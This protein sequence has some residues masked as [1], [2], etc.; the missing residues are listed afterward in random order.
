MTTLPLPLPTLPGFA[1]GIVEV[2]GDLITV[3]CDR[4][5]ETRTDRPVY[6]FRWATIR[7]GERICVECQA[8]TT[9]T[10]VLVTLC[11]TCRRIHPAPRCH[12]PVCGLATLW[13]HEQCGG[14]A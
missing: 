9:P 10:G 14:A 8:A 1:H 2:R 13:G 12:C 11:A 7:D 6:A 5:H 3:Q 4:C